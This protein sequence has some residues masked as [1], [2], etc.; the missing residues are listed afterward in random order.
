[1][2]YRLSRKQK[3][4]LAATLLLL[5]YP[6]LLYIDLPVYTRGGSVSLAMVYHEVMNTVVV[7]VFFFLWTGASEWLLNIL[8]K[9]FGESFLLEFRLPTQ[10]ITL[11]MAIVMGFAFVIASREALAAINATVQYIFHANVLV[12]FPQQHTQEFWDLYKRANIGFFLVLMLSAFYLIA[13]RR[14]HLRLESIRLQAERLEKAG[15]Q[16]QLLALRNQVNPHFLFNSLSILSSLV[17]EDAHLAEKFIDQLARFYRYTL[18][19]E[20]QDTVPL[21]V[22][23]AFI[24]SYIFLLRI[25]FADKLLVTLP[26][27]NLYDNY[28]IAPLTLQLLIENA[29]K[30]NQMSHEQPLLVSITIQDRYLV[31]TNTVLA[32]GQHMPSTRVGLKNIEDRYAL[33]TAAPVAIQESATQFEV[34]VPLLLQHDNQPHHESSYTGR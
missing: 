25:R 18:E 6:V 28:R 24:R 15:T 9:R 32:R 22:E 19:Q 13:N 12:S 26:D 14:A 3:W 10:L 16:A 17:H 2:A 27:G 4:Q 34:K 7:L 20:K 29:V 11:L 23:L 30:H 8:F 5:Y 33:L 31:V 1:M 21:E